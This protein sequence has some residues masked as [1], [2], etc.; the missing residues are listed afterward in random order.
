M[1]NRVS[2]ALR[3]YGFGSQR[4]IPGLDGLRAISIVFVLLAHLSGTRHFPNSRWLMGLGEFGVRVFF[5]IS[6]YLITTILLEELGR[7]GTISLPRFYFR[8]AMRL[9]PAAYFLIM[10]IAAVAALSFIRADRRD[11]LF[12]VT[13]T[14]NYNDAR[15]WQLGHLWSLAVEEQFYLLWPLTLSSLTLPKCRGLLLAVL[16]LGPLFRITSAYVGPAFN[17]LRWSDALAT[18]C[19]LSIMRDAVNSIRSYSRLIASKYFFWVPLTALAANYIPSTKVTWLVGE[20]IMNLAITISVDWAMQN[21]DGSTGRFLNQPTLSFIGVLSYSLYLWQQLFLNRASDR[22]YCIFPLNIV[23]AFPM[24][25]A[26]YLLI[27]APFLRLRK[28][29]EQTWVHRGPE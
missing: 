21:T 5:V 10:V 3:A 22:L 12:A 24:A 29:I 11:I 6:G 25:L 19:L 4:V 7:K 20:T 23:L 14:M 28:L 1:L 26:S 9:F 17:F 27:E 13:Y 8:R 15:G 2:L 18:G 16:V